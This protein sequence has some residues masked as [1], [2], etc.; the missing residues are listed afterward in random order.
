MNLLAVLEYDGTE[1][2]GFQSQRG[3]RTIQ[4][5][6]E[7][8]LAEFTGARVRIVGGGRTDAGVHAEGQTASF[9]MDWQRGLETLQR[10][11]NSK[12]APSLAVK[13][14]LEVPDNFSA[15]YSALS[16]TYR[17]AVLNTPVR[18]PLRERYALWVGAPLDAAVMDR[19]AGELIGRHDFRRFGTPP[20]GDNCVR[21]MIQASAQRQGDRVVFEFEAEAFLYRMVRRL[22]GTLIR[23]GTGRLELDEFK[24]L[25]DPAQTPL[26]RAGNAVPPRGLTLVKIKYDLAF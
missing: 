17:Y 4:D 14:L 20:H 22:V 9:R 18:S 23:V 12:L 7:Q 16:R 5:E 3:G 26:H 6:L 10:A 1:Y 13:S 19:A 25:L 2:L 8:A 15:R 11:L 21:R 24:A